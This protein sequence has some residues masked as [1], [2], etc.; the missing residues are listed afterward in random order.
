MSARQEAAAT[1]WVSRK[2]RGSVFWMR[3][4]VWVTLRL[5]RPVARVLLGPIVAYF[6]VFSVKPRVASKRYL[7]KALD[8][9]PTLIDVFRHYHTFASTIMDRVYFLSDRYRYFDVRLHNPEVLAP[10]AQSGRGC[11][12]VGSH[13]GS[14]EVLRATAVNGPR[15]PVRMLM[16]NG[17]AQ[18]TARIFAELNP[19]LN[20]GIINVGGP[21]SLLRAKEAI[22]AGALVGILGDRVRPGDRYVEC[23][24]FGEKVRLPE[25]PM[26]LAGLLRVP[27]V[28]CFGL[29]RGGRSY[30]VY[31]EVLSEHIELPRGESAP[32]RSAVIAEHMQRYANR[33]EHYARMAPFNW[34]NFYDIWTPTHS[35]RQDHRDVDDRSDRLD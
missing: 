34:F 12:L 25:S 2:E 16:D 10:I 6:L 13:L 17:N 23:T 27:A 28:M 35:P 1:E 18:K 22:E 24:F 4:M 15:W 32:N 29:Y 14:F 3:F 26:M 8:R 30:D 9:R 11:V 19:A 20:Q 7:R 5:G 21:G 33:L 31:F